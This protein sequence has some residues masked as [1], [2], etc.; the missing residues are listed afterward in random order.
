[1]SEY[2]VRWQALVVWGRLY[3]S[4]ALQWIIRSGVKSYTARGRRE[5]AVQDVDP[6]TGVAQHV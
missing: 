4:H 2:G 5:S 1:M 3:G 6:T